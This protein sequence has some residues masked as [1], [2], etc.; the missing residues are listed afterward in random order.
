MGVGRAVVV[1]YRLRGCH[2]VLLFWAMYA[3]RAI[4]RSLTLTIGIVW[5]MV[6][7]PCVSPLS[8]AVI[9]ASL[10]GR[11]VAILGA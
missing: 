8:D 9:K 4:A 1:L 5:F 7:P 3:A 10:A 11:L 2:A 6:P